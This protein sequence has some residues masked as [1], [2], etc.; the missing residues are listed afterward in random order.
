LGGEEL[1]RI[2]RRG[3]VVIRD[4]VPDEQ[5]VRWRE[6]LKEFVQANPQIEGSYC[7]G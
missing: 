4:I 5:A 3:T 1:E 7:V 6:E 2:R